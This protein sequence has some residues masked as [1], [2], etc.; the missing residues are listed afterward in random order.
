MRVT[1]ESKRVVDVGDVA[2]LRMFERVTLDAA[3]AD[4][5]IVIVYCEDETGNQF[6]YLGPLSSLEGVAPGAPFRPE[7]HGELFPLFRPGWPSRDTTADR[8]SA[9]FAFLRDRA[10]TE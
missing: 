8:A 1:V 10:Q 6:S 5:R 4:A 3:E 2:D 7:R 9:A